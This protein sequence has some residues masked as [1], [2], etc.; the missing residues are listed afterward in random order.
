MIVMILT[1]HLRVETLLVI[2]VD[3][4]LLHLLNLLISIK[5]KMK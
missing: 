5:I 1:H 3:L 4:T 2:N